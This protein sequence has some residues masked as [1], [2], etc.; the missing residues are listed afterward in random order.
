MLLGYIS[1]FIDGLSF[2]HTSILLT[3]ALLVHNS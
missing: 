2:N 3:E 1:D